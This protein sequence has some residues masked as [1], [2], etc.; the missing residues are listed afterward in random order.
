VFK[1]LRKLLSPA[2]KWPSN[3]P[4]GRPLLRAKIVSPDDSPGA[5]EGAEVHAYVNLYGP[6]CVLTITTVDD[7]R[8]SRKFRVLCDPAGN[9]TLES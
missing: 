8:I 7:A 5:P 4:V 3:V 9:L 6:G 1:S 2:P